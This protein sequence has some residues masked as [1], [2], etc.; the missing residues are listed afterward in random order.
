MASGTQVE[1][2]VWGWDAP[3]P[4]NQCLEINHYSSPGEVYT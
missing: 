4:W 2:A 3:L 1:G